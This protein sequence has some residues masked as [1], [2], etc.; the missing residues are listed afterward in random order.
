MYYMYMMHSD[1]LAM[2]PAGPSLTKTTRRTTNNN[3]KGEIELISPDKGGLAFGGSVKPNRRQRHP[4]RHSKRLCVT[5]N[6]DHF[7]DS[8]FVSPLSTD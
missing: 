4:T 1:L 6:D 5:D 8:F 3:E 7:D 2:H